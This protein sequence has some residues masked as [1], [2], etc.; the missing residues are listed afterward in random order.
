MINDIL[1]NDVVITKD[2]RRGW[3]INPNSDGK[4]VLRS[5]LTVSSQ[6][7]HRF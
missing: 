2:G 7:M 5:Y 1:R 4:V 6:V 3:V